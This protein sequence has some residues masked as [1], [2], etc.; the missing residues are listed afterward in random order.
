MKGKLHCQLFLVLPVLL[1]SGC[2][3][4]NTKEIVVQPSSRLQVNIGTSPESVLGK[5]VK[6]VD[7]KG[8]AQLGPCVGDFTGYYSGGVSESVATAHEK[9]IFR[10][11][12][13][14]GSDKLLSVGGNVN[15]Y[16]EFK[17]EKLISKVPKADYSEQDLSQLYNSCYSSG[18]Y[19]VDR[20]YS[21]CSATENIEDLEQFKVEKLKDFIS[22]GGFRSGVRVIGEPENFTTGK[23]AKG[24]PSCKYASVIAVDITPVEDVCT[25]I[26]IKRMTSLEKR[27]AEL[28]RKEIELR[29]AN[30]SL[31][32]K[33]HQL[34]NTISTLTNDADKNLKTIGELN[35][36]IVSG[37]KNVQSLLTTSDST[38]KGLEGKLKQAND[39]IAKLNQ[40]VIGNGREHETQVLKFGQEKKSLEEKIAK[41]DSELKDARIALQKNM[42]LREEA[43]AEVKKPQAPSMAN[44]KQ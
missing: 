2:A 31:D 12:G 39:E 11:D 37:D 23:E 24:K 20:A 35:A 29:N 9:G 42:K 8:F 22:L 10:L 33:I 38:I 6:S 1:M 30:S 13:R 21:G 18:Q 5:C 44:A 43:E 4:T 28:E 34:L 15:Y 25:T 36:K 19:I 16:S 7:P 17:I 41:L 3:T 26:K 32:V 40:D 27:N 14:I